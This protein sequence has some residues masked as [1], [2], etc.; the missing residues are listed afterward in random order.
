MFV[1]SLAQVTVDQ[2][3]PPDPY[4]LPVL[5][6]DSLMQFTPAQVSGRRM[7]VQGVVTWSSGG[8]SFFLQDAS[9]GLVVQG[10]HD[11]DV[12]PGD[13]VEAIGFPT[14]GGYAPILQ[15]GDFRKVGRRAQPAPL[16]L[17][18][19]TA[20]S[21]DH[22]AELVRIRGRLLYQSVNGGNRVLTLQLGRST[23][24]AHLAERAVTEG[25][26]SIPDSSRLELAGYGRWRR[27]NTAVLRRIGFCCAH[28]GTLP[29]SSGHPG[30]RAGAC[31][32][33][34]QCC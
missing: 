9:G 19:A 15:D 23:F 32:E 2:P 30:G 10:K 13:L 12:K 29:F 31:S 33:C 1:P 34:W 21:G 6:V 27:T 11:A 20:L 14:A 4:A 24:T 18:A 26:R 16:D 17:T 22:D 7:R 25:V 28:P 8:S 3:S 5:P